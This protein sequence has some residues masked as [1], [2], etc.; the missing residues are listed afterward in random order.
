LTLAARMEAV[1]ELVRTTV[2]V[3]DQNALKELRRTIDALAKRDP[4]FEERVTNKV[5]VLA[6]RVETVAK[7]VSTSSSAVAAKDGEFVQLRRELDVRLARVDAAVQA[8]G[9]GT[10]PAE[11]VEIRRKLDDLSKIAKQRMPRGLEGR[12]D[13]LAAKFELVAQR[14]DSVSSTVSTTASGLAGRDG[15]VNALRRALEAE[16]GRIGAELAVLRRATDPGAV[17]DLRHE[18]KELADENARRL[19]SSRQVIGQ[20]ATK[21][22]A[23]SERLDSFATSLSST[24]DRVAATEQNVLAL[25][26]YLEESGGN[27]KALLGQ[28][29]QSLAA[30]SI[31]VDGF[32][33][34]GGEIT[35]VVDERVS[36]TND[37]IADLRGRLDPLSAAVASTNERLDA[38]DVAL[39]TMERRFEDAS[40][41]INDLVSDLSQA[42]AEFP[43]PSRVEQ[44]LTPRMDELADRTASLADHVAEVETSLLEQRRTS[45]ASSAEFE[46]L[47]AEERETNENL[48]ERLDSLSASLAATARKVSGADEELTALRAYVEEAG[49]RLGSLVAEQKQLLATL[50]TRTASLEQADGQASLSSG[51]E[52][53][54]DLSDRLDGLTGRLES[55]VASMTSAARRV[56]GNEEAVSELR[57]YIEDAGGRLGSLVSEHMQSLAEHTQ[58]LAAL[59][60]RTASLEG[61]EADATRI[62]DE[63]SSETRATVSTLSQRVETLVASVESAVTGLDDKEREL[64]DLHGHFT[65]S[66]SRIE[67][68]VEDIREALGALPHASP[69]AIEEMG[70]K[71]ETTT[72]GLTSLADRL[73]QLEAVHVGHVAAEMTE[74]F[75]RIDERVAAVAAEMGRAKTLWPVALRS[76]EARLD[77]L[78]TRAHHPGQVPRAARANEA[79][80]DR[81]DDALAGLRDSLH[82]MESVAEE[83]AR[84]SE[85]WTADDA[86]ASEPAEATPEAVAGGARIVPLRASDP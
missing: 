10:D 52:R 51:E 41:R 60:A 54:A 28:H 11:L 42:L 2:G 5:D 3:V 79:P 45:N 15:D 24:S 58:S 73:E 64:A 22:D 53:V 7:T 76:L 46:R 83:M 44:A 9:H 72:A 37:K 82:A 30:L 13:E 23:L 16:I 32:E 61:A 38:R 78:V 67:M 35:R 75:D 34:A 55:L 80:E 50:E 31:R 59:S 65:A 26:A 39:Q 43:D 84:A 6:D 56:S 8:V 19:H 40:S 69:N 25:H 86:P 71:L 48:S 70:S 1:E 66:S 33:E 12:I 57:A 27:V 4:K 29:Q 14:V 85:A 47:V 36:A 20:V 17:A 21:V 81:P 77:D 74:R 18:F 49:G 62:F 63:Q 68:I